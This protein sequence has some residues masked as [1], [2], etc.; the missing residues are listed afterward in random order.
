MDGAVDILGHLARQGD[1]RCAAAPD[2]SANL[3]MAEPD[4]GAQQVHG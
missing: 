3:C 2:Q 4:F 1:D